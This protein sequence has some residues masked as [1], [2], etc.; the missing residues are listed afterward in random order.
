VLV[1]TP[2]AERSGD[3]AP[4]GRTVCGLLRADLETHAPMLSR[5]V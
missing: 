2:V 3:H 1:A 4:Y 5:A